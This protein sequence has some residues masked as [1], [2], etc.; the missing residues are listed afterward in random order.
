[1]TVLSQ[2]EASNGNQYTLEPPDQGLC[3]HSGTILEAVNNGLQVYTAAGQA[4]SP[5][6][7][8]NAFFHLP[9]EINFAYNPPTFGPFLSDPKC[10]YDAQTSRWFLTELEIDVNPYS[11]AFGYRS[12]EM[13]AVSQTSDPTGGWG[14]FMIDSTNDG[15]GG[16][17]KDAN[18]PCLGDQPRIGA[19]ANGFYIAT[20]IYAIHGSF[21][22]DG[23]ELYAM[24]K[25]G[26]ASAATGGP[27]RPSWRSTTAR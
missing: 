5:V 7:A 12:A 4:L 21:N 23:G 27:H 11:G 2:A 3:A 26:L 22:S 24:S 20:D 10:Y 17:P 16:T 25:T 19:D 13:I 1:M 9:P 6:I 15:S 14:L 8:L 18:C